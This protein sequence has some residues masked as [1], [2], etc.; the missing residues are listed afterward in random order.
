MSYTTSMRDGR[1]GID[2]QPSSKVRVD[3]PRAPRV[4]QWRVRTD[5]PDRARPTDKAGVSGRAGSRWLER[6]SVV[7]RSTSPAEAVCPLWPAAAPSPGGEATFRVSL[8]GEGIDDVSTTEG[9]R[10]VARRQPP[11]RYDVEEIRAEP[12][13]SGHMPHGQRLSGSVRIV[14]RSLV[15][16]RFLRPESC[17]ATQCMDL[18]DTA[19]SPPA[20]KSFAEF[21]TGRVPDPIGFRS[22]RVEHLATRVPS[23]R[24]NPGGPGIRPCPCQ[25]VKTGFLDRETTCVMGAGTSTPSREFIL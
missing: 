10:E 8:Q 21:S 5:T 1:S 18:D 6:A 11:G 13:P 22:Y 4:F 9:G 25:E 2:L 15:V 14:V 3:W 23:T 7:G 12:F 16:G 24:C 17:H 20:R 19:Q